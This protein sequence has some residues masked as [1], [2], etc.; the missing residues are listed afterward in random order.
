ME[1][2]DKPL[3]ISIAMTS[4]EKHS[5]IDSSMAQECMN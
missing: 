1:S 2:K 5:K 3:H 4:H